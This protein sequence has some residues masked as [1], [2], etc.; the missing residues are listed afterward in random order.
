MGEIGSVTYENNNIADQ[1]NDENVAKM[2]RK[3]SFTNSK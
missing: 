2:A 3:N 1:I